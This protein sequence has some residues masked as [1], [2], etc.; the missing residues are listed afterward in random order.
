M[1]SWLNWFNAE[2]SPKKYWWG[3]RSQEVGEEG[4]YT[5]RY[6]VTTK[7]APALRWAAMRA[8]YVS[9]NAR[10]HVHKP[11]HLKRGKPK[12]N[13]TE[14]LLLTSLTPYRETKPAHNRIFKMFR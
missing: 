8:I 7:L 14:V 10:G 5:K 11:P 4:G 3:P 6:T 12:L 9:L 1:V 2:L 13:R